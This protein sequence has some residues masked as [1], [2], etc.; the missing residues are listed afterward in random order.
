MHV[1]DAAL[2][3]HGGG[4]CVNRRADS[5][6]LLQILLTVQTAAEWMSS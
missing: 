6:Q 4:R 5:A 2:C 3:M 1:V